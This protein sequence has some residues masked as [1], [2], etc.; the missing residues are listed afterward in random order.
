LW[1]ESAK[2]IKSIFDFSKERI[3]VTQGFIGGTTTGHTTTL[4]REGSDYTA[5]ILAISWMRSVLC[6]ERCSRYPEC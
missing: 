4:G 2:R 6:M 1:S 5:A 3:Y